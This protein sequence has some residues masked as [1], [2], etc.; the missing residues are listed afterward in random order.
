MHIRAAAAEGIR[1]RR[2]PTRGA[3][4]A[5]FDTPGTDKPKTVGKPCRKG[6]NYA[7]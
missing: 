1:P 3:A 7:I 5:S 4:F 6:M 2:L